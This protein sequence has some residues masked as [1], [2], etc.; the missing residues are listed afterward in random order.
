MDYDITSILLSPTSLK[1]SCGYF[2]NDV[3]GLN[4]ND[5]EDLSNHWPDDLA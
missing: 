4:Q 2:A 5:N 1:L 3:K